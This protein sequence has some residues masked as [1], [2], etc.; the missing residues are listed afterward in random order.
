ML[1][2]IKQKFTSGNSVEVPGAYVTQ[3]EFQFLLS[4]LRY[5]QVANN[6]VAGDK[7][8]AKDWPEDFGHENG[9]Y[10]CLCHRCKEVFHGY[11]RRVTCKVCHLSMESEDVDRWLWLWNHAENVSFSYRV[12]QHTKAS[13]MGLHCGTLK[14]AVD[15]ARKFKKEK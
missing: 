9:K 2:K 14:D 7:C 1:D 10:Q 8:L 13:V 11:K 4:K 15:S 12:D 5:E 6:P 3:E